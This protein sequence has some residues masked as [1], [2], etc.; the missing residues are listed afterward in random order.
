M[1]TMDDE[2]AVLDAY[3]SG[4]ATIL[5]KSPQGYPIVN[6]DGVTG[7]NVN[8]GSIFPAQPTNVLLLRARSIRAFTQQTQTGHH[9]E[10]ET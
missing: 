3:H 1:D 8:I 6:F 4:S 10:L 2:Q 9:D 7:T 5:G